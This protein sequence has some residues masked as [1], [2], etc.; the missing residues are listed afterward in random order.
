MYLPEKSIIASGPVIVEDGKVLLNRE[1]KESGETLW[2]FPG[3]QMETDDATLEDACRRE[4]KEEMGIE[5][6]II[7]PLHTIL[8]RK[9][10]AM[11]ILC[12]YL[13]V[14]RGEIIP[15]AEIVEW[16]WHDIRNLP[17]NCAPNVFDIIKDLTI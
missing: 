15:G 4:V 10:G 8:V 9:D 16:G 17:P 11:I 1:R 13:A 12:H 7:R 2:M 3:G 14:R 5:I 6:D